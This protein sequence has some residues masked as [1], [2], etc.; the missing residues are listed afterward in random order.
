M[1]DVNM[2]ESTYKPQHKNEYQVDLTKYP[3]YE[4]VSKAPTDDELN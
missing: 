1:G 4:K 3:P 2:C